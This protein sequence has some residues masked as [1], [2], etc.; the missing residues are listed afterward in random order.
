MTKNIESSFYLYFMPK[1]EFIF[2]ALPEQV[3]L[4]VSLLANAFK[5]RH[6]LFYFEPNASFWKLFGITVI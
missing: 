3:N 2:N 4:V 1:K 5:M 6:V